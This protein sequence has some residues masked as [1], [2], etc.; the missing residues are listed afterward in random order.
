MRT[1]SEE[2]LRVQTAGSVAIIE[3]A[4]PH[5]GNALSAAL[6]EALI[7]A[8][9]AAFANPYIQ[10]LV[11]RGAGRHLCTG[12]DLEGIERQSDGDLLHRFVRIELLLSMLWH[13]P[14]RTVA[15][16]SG[17]VYGAGADLFAACD[18]RIA[19]RSTV[20]R[21]PGAGFGIVLGT[22]RLA[23]R[24]GDD[25]AREWLTSNAQIDAETA[26]S[27]GLATD[28]VEEEPDLGRLRALTVDRSTHRAL[29]EAS[30]E[31]CRDRDLAALVRSAAVPGLKD[32]ITAYV[33]RLKATG[34][35]RS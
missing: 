1:V 21:F 26:L 27:A 7:D 16:G 23:A 6:V 17:N 33:S 35:V 5:R 8:V 15:L 20:F 10:T 28:V 13:A 12:F 4:R 22:R 2:P 30:R 9:T 19:Q 31:D 29:Y 11:I 14:L 18:R 25:F 34:S 24:V 3:L 32:R